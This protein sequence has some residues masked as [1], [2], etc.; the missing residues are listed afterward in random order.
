MERRCFLSSSGLLS[1]GLITRGVSG[2]A[3]ADSRPVD[4]RDRIEA[5]TQAL[6]P[7]VQQARETALQILKPTT[8]QL[9]RGLRLHAESIV[10]DASGFAPRSAVDQNRIKQLTDAGASDLELDEA[11]E[12]MMMTRCVSDP[13]EQ[14][15]FRESW[16]AAG[17]T[18]IFQNAGQEGQ[19]P[20]RLLRRLARFTWV[21]DMLREFTGK[22][23]IPADIRQAHADGRH[24]LYLTGNGIPLLQRWDTPEEE[25]LNLRLFFQLG[26]RMMHLTYQRR[27][28]IGDGCGESSNA[29][30]SDFGRQAIRELNRNGI[31]PDCA[32]SGWQ[33][34]LEAAKASELP[35]V[36]SH[37]TAAGIFP[38]IRSKPDNVIR[39]IADS[40]GYV[41][42]CCIP[43]FLRG[44]GDLNA[45]L[46]H[47]E[48]VARRFGCEHVAIGT[49]VAAASPF[50]LPADGTVPPRRR[51]A[52]FR[53]LWPADSFSETPEMRNSISWTNWPMFTVG[54]VQR[55]FT[56]DEIRLIVGE[57]VMRVASQTLEAVTV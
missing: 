37:T 18:C 42:I 46:D 21:T 8:K 7:A 27:N 38:H 17:V 10:F 13:D 48:Y 33:T 22:A 55:G 34:S 51:R 24:M 53:S 14:R 25:L 12:D 45:F 16:N 15:A 39:A 11:R 1:A 54:L 41:G 52:A 44:K 5:L 50:R 2:T 36:A 56:D 30:L 3:V 26:V 4:I 6:P 29:G 49:D 23:V 40:G 9:E 31:I 20:S 19:D 35:V 32:H 47:I 43:R 57:N 28:M